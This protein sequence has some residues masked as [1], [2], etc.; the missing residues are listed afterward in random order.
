[1]YGAFLSHAQLETYLRLLT[2]RELLA[3]NSNRYVTTE[4]GHAFLE[5]FAQLSDVLDEGARRTF[6]E[7]IGE[8]KAIKENQ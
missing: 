3:H 7:I 6:V 4:K 1:M 8:T 5:A 2:K